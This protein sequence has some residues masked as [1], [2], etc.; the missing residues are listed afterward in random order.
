MVFSGSGQLITFMI[1]FNSIALLKNV[2]NYAI[3]VNTLLGRATNLFEYE[4]DRGVEHV[5]KAGNGVIIY[6]DPRG[7]D[8][9]VLIILFCGTPHNPFIHA[10]LI[11]MSANRNV[12]YIVAII[13]QYPSW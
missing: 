5:G 6:G 10:I 7:K 3:L 12:A 8:D 13:T 2:L 1:I 4:M 9:H 11:I